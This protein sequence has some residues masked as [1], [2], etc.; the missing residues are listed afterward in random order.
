VGNLVNSF[1][2]SSLLPSNEV[3]THPTLFYVFVLIVEFSSLPTHNVKMILPR[4]KEKSPR[5]YVNPS[6]QLNFGLW[7]LFAGASAF[8]GL[9]IWVKLTRRNH[10]WYDD[11]ILIVSWVRKFA[12]FAT[13]KRLPV[14]R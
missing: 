13:R 3:A 5:V 12:S 2:L 7:T 1:S 9:R 11:Y 8:L 6:L 4:K 14:S 10:L